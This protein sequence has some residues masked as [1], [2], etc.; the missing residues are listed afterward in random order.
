MDREYVKSIVDNADMLESPMQYVSSELSPI[1]V[2][3]PEYL[4]ITSENL[5]NTFQTLAD[6]K[7]KKGVPSIIE[8]VENVVKKYRGADTQEKIRNYLTDIE[9]VYGSLFV[10]LG[11]DTNIIPARVKKVGKVVKR[12]YMLWITIMLV[13]EEEIGMLVVIVCM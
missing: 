4:I 6:W 3:I 11:G 9:S 7:T 5:R 1:E 8:T 2:T 13:L 10:L 12:V